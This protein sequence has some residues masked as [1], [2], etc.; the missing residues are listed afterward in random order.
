MTQFTDI[1]GKRYGRLVVL[2]LGERRNGKRFWLCRCDC[3]VEKDIGWGCLRW[4]YTKSCGCYHNEVSSQKC[5]ARKTHGESRTRLYNI[6]LKMNDRCSDPANPSWVNYG[7]RGIDVCEEWCDSP[8]EFVAWAKRSGYSPESTIERV[9][10]NGS[11]GPANC[12]WASRLEQNQNKRSNINAT[13]KG[14]TRCVSEWERITGVGRK[15]I[16]WRIRAGIPHEI[17]VSA[18]GHSIRKSHL[19]VA[20]A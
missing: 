15:T 2:R 16:A 14:V 10:N 7:G 1:T 19:A 5:K 9:D 11:Y 6:W 17:A 13:V 12:R 4:G 3:G 18:P 20:S 8:T